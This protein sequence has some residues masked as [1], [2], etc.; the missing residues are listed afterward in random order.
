MYT[1]LIVDDEKIERNGIKFLLKKQAEPFEIY[2]A[3]NGKAALEQLCSM[4]NQGKKIDILIFFH[5]DVFSVVI[6][7]K[8][9]NMRK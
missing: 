7:V 1:I 6:A 2:E 9:R 4:R 8:I 3:P 5:G